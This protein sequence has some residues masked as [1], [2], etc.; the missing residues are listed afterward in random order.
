MMVN[1][2][3]KKIKNE[4]MNVKLSSHDIKKKKHNFILTFFRTLPF[5]FILMNNIKYDI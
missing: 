1:Y 5:F 4:Q 2:E 3:N